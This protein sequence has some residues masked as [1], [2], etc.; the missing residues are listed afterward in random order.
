MQEHTA[1]TVP[2][3]EATEYERIFF[4]VAP[5]YLSTDAWDTKTAMAPAIKKAGIRQVKTCFLAYSWSIIKA[6]SP[7]WRIVGLSHGI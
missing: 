3:T 7:D 4:A 6:S 5:K 1:K 2:E